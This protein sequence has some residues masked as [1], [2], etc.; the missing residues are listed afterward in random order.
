[1]II[2]TLGYFIEMIFWQSHFSGINILLSVLYINESTENK[3]C[4]F[5]EKL[6]FIC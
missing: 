6:D 3:I 1:M 2:V 4:R 5:E